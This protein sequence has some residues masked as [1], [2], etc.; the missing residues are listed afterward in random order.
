MW[1]ALKQHFRWARNP[2]QEFEDRFVEEIG[3]HGGNAGNNDGLAQ[4]CQLAAHH[5]PYQQKGHDGSFENQED[6][7]TEAGINHTKAVGIEGKMAGDRS[8][9]PDEGDGGAD[10]GG[11][12]AEQPE[13][14]AL[15]RM[16][17]R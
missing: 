13:T 9:D 2:K 1:G 14:K 8:V 5:A 3:A 12:Q 6:Y 16:R 7:A 4:W 11:Y 10:D 15:K 17:G